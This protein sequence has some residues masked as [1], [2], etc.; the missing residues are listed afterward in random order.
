MTSRDA[1]ISRDS[2]AQPWNAPSPI[3]FDSSQGI[4]QRII[5]SH[6]NWSKKRI[7]LN[8]PLFERNGVMRSLSNV[9][10][11]KEL[12]SQYLKV[13]EMPTN[14]GDTVSCVTCFT[15]CLGSVPMNIIWFPT[16]NQSCLASS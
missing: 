12:F 1:G 15:T 14:R 2:K 8:F 13:D 11:L 7:D 5:D 10:W 3:V 16:E 9:H 6:W 4:L